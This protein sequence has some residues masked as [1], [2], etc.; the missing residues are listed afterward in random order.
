M[1]QADRLRRLLAYW[2]EK[3]GAAAMPARADISPFDFT[4]VLGDV[5][6]AE[7]L[8]DPLRFRYR[9][10]GVNLVARD[11]FDMTG[12]L[13]S[14]H[15]EPGYRDRIARTWTGVA[16]TGKPSHALREIAVDGR[17]RRYESLVLPLGADRTRTDM[18]L[19]AQIY[20]G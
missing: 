8:R 18:L 13:L 14:D 11:G 17:M 7:V 12:K 15:P 2:N 4:Y 5:V 6:L 9:L 1:I 16:Q 20:I 10:H 3:R 19:G